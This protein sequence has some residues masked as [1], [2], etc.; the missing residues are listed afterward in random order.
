M[1]SLVA[2]GNG[3]QKVMGRN[4]CAVALAVVL[5]ALMLSLCGCGQPQAQADLADE[6]RSD[7]FRH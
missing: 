2:E 1:K 5:C 7:A 3:K 4:W 6:Y